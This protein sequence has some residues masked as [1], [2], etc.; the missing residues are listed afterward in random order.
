MSESKT[1]DTTSSSA[2]EGT[3]TKYAPTPFPKGLKIPQ[4]FSAKGRIATQPFRDMSVKTSINGAGAVKVAR[5]EN[6]VTLTP[7]MVV[8]DSEDERVTEG[9]V[10]LVKSSCYTAP[11]AKEI[12]STGEFEFILVPDGAVEVICEG[13]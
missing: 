7:L 3:T 8:F 5:I 6:K 13:E 4:K 11:W 10:I 2:P 1:T 12:Y 9:D